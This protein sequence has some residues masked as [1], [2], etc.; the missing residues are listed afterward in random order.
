MDQPCRRKASITRSHNTKTLG[1]TNQVYSINTSHVEKKM[2]EYQ[3]VCIGIDWEG[4]GVFSSSTNT[5][6]SSF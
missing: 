2:T 4:N 6:F 1:Q 5:A 3:V